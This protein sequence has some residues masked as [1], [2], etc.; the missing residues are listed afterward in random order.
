MRKV[1]LFV[2]FLFLGLTYGQNTK[3]I[4][5]KD[6][7]G[8]WEFVKTEYNDGEDRIDDECWEKN[9][10]IFTSTTITFIN[11]EDSFGEEECS[12]LPDEK[13]SYTISENTLFIKIPEGT[14][15]KAPISLSGKT[16]KIFFSDTFVNIYRKK[17][18]K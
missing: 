9:K 17:E 1:A 10:L 3:K 4:T 13:L 12:K 2:S 5:S 8:T 6:L 16:L 7:I 18:T 14:T 11:Y 15:E